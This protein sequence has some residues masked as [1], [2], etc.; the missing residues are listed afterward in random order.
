MG[1]RTRL[2]QVAGASGRQELVLDADGPPEIQVTN[3]TATRH[4]RRD[5]E[6]TTIRGAKIVHGW[7]RTWTIDRLHASSPELITSKHVRAASRLVDD[8]QASQGISMG[9][10]A[11][12]EGAR[13][14]PVEVRIA[15]SR[16]YESAMMAVGLEGAYLVFHAAIE[17]QTMEW[18]SE[19]LGINRAV[20]L[21]L[22]SASLTRL[23]DHYT[24]PAPMSSVIAAIMEMIDKGVSHIPQ[25][26]LGRWRAQ[27][28]G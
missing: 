11:P 15:A 1:K 13:L 27:I 26:R 2:K 23:R 25:E 4:T 5:P 18:I 24:P 7:R 14:D 20:L 17:G 16:R 19:R 8:F 6:D 9:G 12:T 10:R 21:G 3:T 22:L 28:I